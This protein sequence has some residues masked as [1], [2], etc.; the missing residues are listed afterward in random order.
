MPTNEVNTH[1]TPPSTPGNARENLSGVPRCG[2]NGQVASA[3]WIRV[4]LAGGEIIER[5]LVGAS[6]LGVEV[7]N[8]S[9]DSMRSICSD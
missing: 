2:R 3:E 7:M 8:L 5:H 6:D 1:P 9:G 4:A